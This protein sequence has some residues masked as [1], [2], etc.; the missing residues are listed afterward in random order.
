MLP[1]ITFLFVA[2]VNPFAEWPWI[3]R[4]YS[5]EPCN[6][7]V[8]EEL[9]AINNTSLQLEIA[10]ATLND[11]K[12]NGADETKLASLCDFIELKKTLT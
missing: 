8:F 9:E 4:E 1:L 6:K 2:S 3:S 7:D 5:K 11:M 10:Q 12:I